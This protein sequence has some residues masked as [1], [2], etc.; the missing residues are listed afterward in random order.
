M[1]LTRNQPSASAGITLPIP[2]QNAW[3]EVRLAGMGMSVPAPTQY[4]VDQPCSAEHGSIGG[5]LR[6]DGKEVAFTLL[7]RPLAYWS[8]K[9]IDQSSESLDVSALQQEF[10]RQALART[11]R[12]ARHADAGSETYGP[13][14]RCGHH[15][16]VIDLSL[17]VRRRVRGLTL[18]RRQA[19]WTCTVSER[20]VAIEM[21]S[22][23]DGQDHI[24]QYWT[25]ML[26]SVT[27]HWPNAGSGGEESVV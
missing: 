12:D 11:R 5:W 17:A 14:G 23:R 18:F 3:E 2:R 20:H 8:V 1:T 25:R 6:N 7:W 26:A 27:C 19:L 22:F 24:D 13:V 15:G 4:R 21:S 10:V 16:D 9:P